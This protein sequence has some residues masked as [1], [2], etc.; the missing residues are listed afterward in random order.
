MGKRTIVLVGPMAP[1]PGGIATHVAAWQEILRQRGVACHVVDPARGQMHFARTLL[2]AAAQPA[3]VHVHVCGHNR[4]SYALLTLCQGVSHTCIVTLHSGLVPVYFRRVGR[5][6]RGLIARVL[7]RTATVVCVSHAVWNAARALGV[8]ENKLVLAPAFLRVATPSAILPA[9]RAARGQGRRL[10]AAALGE[11]REYGADLLVAAFAHVAARE[12]DLLL[13]T[14]GPGDKDVPRALAAYGLPERA[15][16][17]GTLAHAHAVGV[18]AACDL[19]VRPTRA[20][21]DSLSVREAM[22]LG[23]RVVASD[24]AARPSGVRVV[25]VGD[26]RALAGAMRASLEE[27]A[28]KATHADFSAPLAALYQRL[29]AWETTECAALPAV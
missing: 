8:S 20:D 13:V 23:T 26:A 10:V 5:F 2:V 14:F 27:P 16:A 18:L 7:E 3:I 22:A 1:P 11:G 21:G 29:G 25:P 28:P 4:A 17:L 6:G 12:T 24:A 9:L 15:L 19:F